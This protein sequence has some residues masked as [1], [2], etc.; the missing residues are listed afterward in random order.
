MP[1]CAALL[2]QIPDR[3]VLFAG[4]VVPVDLIGGPQRAVANLLPTALWSIPLANVM[5]VPWV[6]VTEV[7]QVAAMAAA[8]DSQISGRIPVDR[9]I[10]LAAAV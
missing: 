7:G 5:L 10:E 4:S 9:M 2:P 6:T 3:R 8:P 1:L